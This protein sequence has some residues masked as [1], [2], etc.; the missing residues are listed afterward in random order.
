MKDLSVEAEIEAPFQLFCGKDD[1]QSGIKRQNASPVGMRGVILNGA[2][3]EGVFAEHEPG[4]L[5]SRAENLGES[6]ATIELPMELAARKKF[7]AEWASKAK[8]A[9]K[10]GGAFSVLLLP[11]AAC[12]GGDSSSTTA[13]SSTTGYVI[14][15]YIKNAFLFRDEDGDGVFDDGEAAAYTNDSGQYTLGGSSTASIVVDPSQD[16]EGR[17]AVDLDKPDEA[18]TSVLK[19]PAGSTVVTPLT[20]IVQEIVATGENVETAQ[21]AVRTALG[22]TGDVDVTS[23]DPI[24]SGNTEVYKAGVQVAGLMSASGGGEAGLE[25][26]KA[27]ATAVK[28]AA[29]TSS[30]V[31][32]SDASAVKAV[33]EAAQAS[34]RGDGG[35]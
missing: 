4:A 10:K 12:G 21:A 32:L 31:D 3:A 6:L 14:D 29:D 1:T 34:I 23:L 15:G 26:T 35:R 22:I 8:K 20:T 19:A 27:L 2:Q 13:P 17:T 9:S 25:V 33:V 5:V 18:F 28:A 11:L 30:S 7:I 24:A 16:P